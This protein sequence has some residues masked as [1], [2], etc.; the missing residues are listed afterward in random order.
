MIVSYCYVFYLMVSFF[1]QSIYEL[2]P[3]TGVCCFICFYVWFWNKDNCD[4]SG[5]FETRKQILNKNGY[6]LGCSSSDPLGV[7]VL[8][9]DPLG[10]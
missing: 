2:C 3:H 8:A 1:G 6:V 10:V 5:M 9:P 4:Q 7:Y